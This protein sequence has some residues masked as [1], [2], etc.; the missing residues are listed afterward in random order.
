M[1]AEDIADLKEMCEEGE[2]TFLD[3]KYDAAIIG[4]F[5][6]F[7]ESDMPCYDIEKIAKIEGKPLEAEDYESME[8]YAS[9]TLT[10][11]DI[12]NVALILKKSIEEIGEEFPNVLAP[13]G[14]EDT[15]MG[16]IIR[17]I[18]IAAFNKDSIVALLAKDFSVDPSEEDEEEE[19]DVYF[20][21]VEYFDYNII[22]AWMGETT[23]A[24]IWTY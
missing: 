12:D 1:K 8:F 22:G 10:I 5:S 17:D 11:K 6:R 2:I 16:I 3:N 9:A 21:A 20:E 4:I 15:C 13:D 23:P 24:F 18:P 7:G 19:R 14:Y